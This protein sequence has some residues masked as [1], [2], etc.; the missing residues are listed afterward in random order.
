MEKYNHNINLLD[1]LDSISKIHE[2]KRDQIDEIFQKIA[3][4]ILKSVRLERLSVWLLNENKD[5]LTSIGEFDA[6]TD[7]FQKNT[8]FTK[9]ALPYCFKKLCSEEISVFSNELENQ[10]RIKFIELYLKPNDVISSITIPIRIASEFIGVLRIEKTGSV[11]RV[12]TQDEKSFVYSSGLILASALEARYRRRLQAE[13]NDLLEEKKMLITEID[14]RV[15]NNFAILIGLLRRYKAKSDSEDVISIL[16]EFEQRIFSMH[17]VHNMLG[18]REGYFE[19]NFTNYLNELFTEFKL[20]APN[21]ESQIGTVIHGDYI[22]N[23]K[24]AIHFGL[25]LTEIFINSLKYSNSTQTNYFFKLE[26]KKG[27][28]SSEDQ[29][30]ITDSGAGFDFEEKI[31]L[32]STGLTLVQDLIDDLELQADYPIKGM[33]IY[34]FSL[35]LKG[36]RLV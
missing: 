27:H 6:R 9:E 8:V 30:I 18:E 13:L 21:E 1:E 28:S 19:I 22:V 34:K 24:T 10:S 20:Q 33:S 14:H 25:L 32:G 36:E 4:P 29:I 23:S 12:F 3:K 16:D 11:E 2:L 17:K 31:K 5:R 26:I 15:K 7:Q 35:K